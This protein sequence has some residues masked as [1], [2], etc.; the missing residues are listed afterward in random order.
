M[1]AV[2]LVRPYTNTVLMELLDYDR[3]AAQHRA[4]FE[5][6]EAREADRAATAL[7]AHCPTS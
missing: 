5:G 3:V 6:I 2:H 4:I 1:K 7:R